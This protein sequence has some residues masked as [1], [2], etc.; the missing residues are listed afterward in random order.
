MTNIL[1]W[2]KFILRKLP[3]HLVPQMDNILQD[4]KFILFQIVGRE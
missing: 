4:K 2:G 1:N 3:R